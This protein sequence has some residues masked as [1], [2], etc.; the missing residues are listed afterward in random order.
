MDTRI[1]QAPP[2]YVRKKTKKKKPILKI[3]IG[4]VL[5]L[6]ISY[7]LL[8]LIIIP[9]RP[10]YTFFETNKDEPLVIAQHGGVSLAPENTLIAFERSLDIGVDI[11]QI[12]VRQT[13]DYELVVIKDETVDRTTNGEGYVKELTLS[14]I[15]ELDAAHR[16]RDSRGNHVYR[17]HGIQV[18]TLEEVFQTFPDTRFLIYLRDDYEKAI[19]VEH[20]LW[21]LIKQYNMEEN[22][23]IY[24]H[25]DSMMNALKEVIEAQIPLGTSRAEM[26]RLVF[27]HKLFIERLYRPNADA[28]ILPSEYTVFNLKDQRIIEGAQRFNMPVI[29]WDIEQEDEMLEIIE[30]GANAI[31]TERPDLMIRLLNDIKQQNDS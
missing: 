11:I 1:H 9:E 30:R 19:D 8:Y 20:K 6:V 25:D 12:D 17:G 16:F 13:E 23:L 26:Q 15:K 14:S 10:N 18:P 4:L 27:M 2:V 28:L 3:L 31:V 22:V 21:A 7:F 29:F 5:F 24:S